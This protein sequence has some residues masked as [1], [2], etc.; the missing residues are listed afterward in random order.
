MVKNCGTC[1]VGWVDL[2]LVTC[3][4]TVVQNCCLSYLPVATALL[5]LTS[6]LSFFFFSLLK[7]PKHKIYIL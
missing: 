7:N 1:E 2:D 4:V 5:C 3:Y 6:F